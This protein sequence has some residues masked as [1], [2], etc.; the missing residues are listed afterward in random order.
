MQFEGSVTH[1]A[2]LVCYLSTRFVPLCGLT[3][4]FSGQGRAAIQPHPWLQPCGLAAERG[5]QANT[6]RCA[7]TDSCRTTGPCSG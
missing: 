1:A 3:N 6:G 2:G 4:R 5:R 7:K